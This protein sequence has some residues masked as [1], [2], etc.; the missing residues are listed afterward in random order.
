M[1]NSGSKAWHGV[2]NKMSMEIP[3]KKKKKVLNLKILCLV[4][5]EETVNIYMI[6]HSMWTTQQ[7]SSS[8]D[9]RGFQ[10]LPRTLKT[11]EAKSARAHITLQSN[12]F[13]LY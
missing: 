5:D 1:S 4:T 3:R 6:A 12:T 9:D 11:E 8:R 10:E 13:S 2:T 7:Y